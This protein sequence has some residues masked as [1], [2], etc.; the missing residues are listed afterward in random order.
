MIDRLTQLVTEAKKHEDRLILLVEEILRSRP[1][2]RSL[3][4]QP[5][6]PAQIAIYEQVKAQLLANL[7]QEINKFNPDKITV[8]DWAKELRSRVFKAVLIDDNLKQLAL[9][10][11]GLEP[12]TELRRHLLGELVEAI[13]LSGRLC[14]P[15][16]EKFSPDFYELIYEEA[17]IR[18]LGYV[19]KNIDKYDQN[20]G[21]NLKFTN[22]VNFRLERFLIE[23]RR[24]FNEAMV[25]ELPNLSDLENLSEPPPDTLFE[26]TRQYIE[27]D[28]DDCFKG[29]FIR[30]RP[31]VN[32]QA[33]ALARFAG[34]SWE[35]ISVNFDI[36]ISTLSSFFQRGC[37]KFHHKFKEDLGME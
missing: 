15:Q 29:E 34:K 36:K 3:S 19:C 22:W 35:E 8:K 16:R 31:D 6:T 27:A 33:I 2:C 7:A 37:Q 12:R 17:V 1:I 28:P 14:R 4:G 32:F 30:H 24:D 25:D 20:R 26:D 18:T 11:Q 23:C 13:R 10:I 9:E 21:E 5:L